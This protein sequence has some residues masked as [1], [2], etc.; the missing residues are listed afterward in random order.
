M[1]IENTKA[2]PQRI[3]NRDVLRQKQIIFQ[4]QIITKD[5]HEDVTN[6]MCAQQPYQC[7]GS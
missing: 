3:T 7:V 1:L 6:I 4:E 2:F 5:S